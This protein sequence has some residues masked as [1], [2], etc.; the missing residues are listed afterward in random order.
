VIPVH[1]ERPHLH[2]HAELAR[3]CQVPQTII[4]ENGTIIRL[5]PGRAEAVARAA[6]GVLAVD[7]N[8]TVPIE[9]KIITQRYRLVEQ[10]AVVL[11]LVL[12]HKGRVLAKPRLSSFAL[13]E[14]H[15]DETLRGAE[16]AVSRTLQELEFEELRDDEAVREAVRLAVRHHFT[17]RLGKRP[18]VDV[19]LIRVGS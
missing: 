4:P 14:S 7:G 11:A 9:S 15:E 6:T 5:G 10:G 1:G 2:A 16:Q 18:I 3:E 19:Q 17:S 8:R 12:D 13:A